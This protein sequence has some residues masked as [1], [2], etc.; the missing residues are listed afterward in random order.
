MR[1]PLFSSASHIACFPVAY[2]RELQCF[3]RSAALQSP[4]RLTGPCL[5]L[6]AAAA[7]AHHW[8]AQATVR[9]MSRSRL[10]RRHR[11]RPARR[12][13][14]SP[15]GG[16]GLRAACGWLVGAA[17]A[18]WEVCSGAGKVPPHAWQRPCS[19]GSTNCVLV[20]GAGSPPRRL[21][22]AP[23]RR[24]RRSSVVG[25]GLRQLLVPA[26]TMQRAPPSSP[27]RSPWVCTGTGTG[28]CRDWRRGLASSMEEVAESS[29]R[30]RLSS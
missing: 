9:H 26:L 30:W 11:P 15:T 23:A 20:C 1:L 19:S 8:L 13:A 28:C 14:R 3:L 27:F 6:P 5:L 18:A 4:F 16:C 2:E 7:L 21:R 24:G 17:A 12:E 25:A 29:S 22:T 10:R